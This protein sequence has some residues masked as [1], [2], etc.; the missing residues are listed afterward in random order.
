MK[1]T[2]KLEYCFFKKKEKQKMTL[3]ET[4]V[5]ILRIAWTISGCLFV[6]VLSIIIYQA[7]KSSL[8]SEKQHRNNLFQVDYFCKDLTEAQKFTEVG[9]TFLIDK[10][11]TDVETGVYLLKEDSHLMKLNVPEPH[12]LYK[13]RSGTFSHYIHEV[14]AIGH[15]GPSYLAK[16]W[17]IEDVSHLALNDASVHKVYFKHKSPQELHVNVELETDTDVTI[18]NLSQHVILDLPQNVFILPGK[19]LHFFY[20]E[21]K[22]V[23]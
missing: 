19:Y 22:L 17:E 23:F 13:I 6:I 8:E 18:V 1:F 4:C 16:K 21:G 12:Q 15:A 7:W 20:F 10:G 11:Q 2:K 9:S 14:K 5:S 3:A